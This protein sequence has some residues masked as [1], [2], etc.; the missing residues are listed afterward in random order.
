MERARAIE[1]RRFEAE[2]AAVDG[3]SHRF[4]GLHGLS[5]AKVGL[6]RHFDGL[7]RIAM[8]VKLT[9]RQ[10]LSVIVPLVR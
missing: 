2:A 3:K 9:I 10:L 1:Y 4:H 8:C 5:L 7:T 6:E